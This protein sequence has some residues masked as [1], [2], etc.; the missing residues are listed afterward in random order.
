MDPREYERLAD[1][2]LEDIA[3][4]LEDFDPDEVDFATSDGVVTIEFPDGTRY[5]LNRQA[6][7]HQMWYAAGARAWHYNWNSDVS[8]WQDDRDQHSLG[9][10]VAETI[11]AKLGRTVTAPS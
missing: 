5:V 1:K 11:S 10:C 9:S 3:G 8:D 6:A 7:A 4:W 2:C